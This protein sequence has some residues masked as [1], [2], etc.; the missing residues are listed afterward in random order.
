VRLC[1][2]GARAPVCI[3]VHAVFAEGAEQRLR[4]AGA[5][6]I[7]TTNTIEHPTNAIDIA[8]VL[9]AAVAQMLKL[10]GDS[11]RSGAFDDAGR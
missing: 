10:K 1:E 2:A 8:P 11:R 4:D 7:A 9:I 3:A 6:R 5:A